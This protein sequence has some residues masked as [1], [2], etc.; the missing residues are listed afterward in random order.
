MPARNPQAFTLNLAAAKD[1][2]EELHAKVCQYYTK[3]TL[4]Y[5]NKTMRVALRGL[6][7]DTKGV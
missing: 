2:L 4:W 5:F 7:V 6:Y 1:Q 3:L